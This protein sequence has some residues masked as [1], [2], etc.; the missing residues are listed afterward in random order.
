M[1]ASLVAVPPL[2]RS[3]V[4]ATKKAATTGAIFTGYVVG[5]VASSY[6]VVASESNKRYPS[7]W[8]SIIVSMVASSL[9]SLVLRFVLVRENRR[10]DVALAATEQEANDMPSLASGGEKAHRVLSNQQKEKNEA[11][12]LEADLDAQAP[13]IN[14]NEYVDLTDKQIPEFRYTL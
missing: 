14:I 4:G 13:P 5:N 1:P 10:R 9:C 3:L 8:I 2:L 12:G 7:A 11:L 6:S